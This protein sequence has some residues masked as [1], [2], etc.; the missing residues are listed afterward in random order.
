MAG[1]V[2]IYTPVDATPILGIKG[3]F[4]VL[5]ATVTAHVTRL[6]IPY[7]EVA[8]WEAGRGQRV[9]LLTAAEFES[10]RRSF[11]KPEQEA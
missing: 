8:T 5:A 10:W 4:I 6:G 7:L 1:V 2:A 3:G 9:E 11:A